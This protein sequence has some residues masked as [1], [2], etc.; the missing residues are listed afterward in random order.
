[1]IDIDNFKPVNDSLGHS[2]G[3][4][5]LK[6]LAQRLSQQ[7][8]GYDFAARYGGDEFTLLLS[9]SSIG[10]AVAVA[11][12]IRHLI[13]SQPFLRLE[14][15]SI[16]LT[17][18]IGI[19][20]FSGFELSNEEQLIITADR[21]LHEAK[22]TGRNCIAIAESFDRF[23]VDPPQGLYRRNYRKYKR[24][25]FLATVKLINLETKEATEAYTIN[26]SYGGLAVYVQ[27]PIP[28]KGRVQ[29]WIPFTDS[30]GKPLEEAVEGTV[31][32]IRQYK[33]FYGIGIE[34]VEV[35]RKNHQIVLNFIQEAE[36]LSP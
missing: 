11:H 17:I 15:N 23:R 32:W 29:V 30:T 6:E 34:F 5:V 31:R 1:M 19:A 21:A 20:A 9:Q 2:I 13:D 14:G 16:H 24:H 10:G 28:E 26:I 25:P 12:R 33:D 35:N 18:S 3:D 4:R 8:R 22:Q 36:R 27:K 7:M